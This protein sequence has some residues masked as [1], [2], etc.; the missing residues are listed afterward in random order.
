MTPVAYRGCGCRTGLKQQ[1]FQAPLDQVRR[2]RQ[3]DRAATDYGDRERIPVHG[4]F[5]LAVAT[6]GSAS[7]VR[8]GF[9]TQAARPRPQQFSVRKPTK[10]FM[11]AKS[12]A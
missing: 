4:A 5:L 2:G 12:A 10:S 1:G 11:T 7:V 8:A 3:C 6:E 9:G